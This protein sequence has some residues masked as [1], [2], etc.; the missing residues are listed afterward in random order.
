MSTKIQN[1][2]LT[3][4]SVK[5]KVEFNVK[6]SN[7]SSKVYKVEVEF[8]FDNV[9]V[10]ELLKQ[11]ERSLIIAVQRKLRDSAKTETEFAELVKEYN[12]KELS[13]KELITA[14]RERT[15]KPETR[16]REMVKAVRLA[17]KYNTAVAEQMW[18]DV[19]IFAKENG[20]ELPEKP[21]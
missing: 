3:L 11:A 9:T 18:K 17:A 4:D 15:A 2:D 16:L 21:F 7:K 12:G 1:T 5:R 20:L 10:A 14:Q 8:N 19:V 6:H 13:V